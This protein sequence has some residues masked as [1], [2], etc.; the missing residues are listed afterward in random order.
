VTAAP[1]IEPSGAI[2]GWLWHTMRPGDR[3][4]AART[5]SIFLMVAGVLLAARN[6]IAQA[7]YGSPEPSGVP[8]SAAGFVIGTIV[9]PLV[10]VGAALILPRR[11][12]VQSVLLGL[13]L[14]LASVTLI[15]VLQIGFRDY[16]AGS[17]LYVVF[18]VVWSAYYMRPVAC[19]ITVAVTLVGAIIVA[20]QRPGGL[21][22]SGIVYLMVSIVL[23]AGMILRLRM[24]TEATEAQL[25]RRLRTDALTGIATRQVL[26]GVGAARIAEARASG[27]TVA[28]IVIDVDDFKSIN[29]GDGHP[30]GDAV[31]RHLGEQL[32]AAAGPRDVATR[33]GGD[34]FAL[35]LA[36]A[37]SRSAVEVAE[38]L[39]EAVRRSP[40]ALPDG[41]GTVGYT[42]SMGVAT[43]EDG[44]DDIESLY[45]TADR[46]LYR[47]KA[48]GRDRVATAT[49]TA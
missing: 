22:Y 4:S 18:V 15:C 39:L 38:L 24:D 7:L 17:Q 47:A 37:T 20:L 11:R 2:R 41:E 12:T 13:P 46:A 40:V 21:A 45:A 14:P 5:G 48:A 9:V 32:S 36:D 43:T 35:L 1:L 19:V 31:L 25:E 26:D 33:W 16:S 3:V 28:L 27:S 30:A 8:V 34:E 10:L 29:D 44:T 49:A 6:L 23:V 42:I